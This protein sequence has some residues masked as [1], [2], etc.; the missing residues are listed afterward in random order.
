LGTETTIGIV[1]PPRNVRLL[2]HNKEV[3][4]WRVVEPA[5]MHIFKKHLSSL[6][7]LDCRALLR[8]IGHGFEAV[9][10][11][12]MHSKQVSLASCENLTVSPS[13]L[14]S[15]QLATVTSSLGD[16]QTKLAAAHERISSQD[17]LL[18][19]CNMIFDRLAQ[20]L[21]DYHKTSQMY[22]Y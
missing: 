8:N 6:G 2:P 3:Y 16:V 13:N 4:G 22:S 18:F 9:L 21:D 20:A 7:T 5:I 10:K 14:I 1:V 15:E 17:A 19:Q 11:T 12:D